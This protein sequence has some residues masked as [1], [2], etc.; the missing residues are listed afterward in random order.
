MKLGKTTGEL[1]NKTSEGQCK[2]G[3]ERWNIEDQT[4]SNDKG[5]YQCQV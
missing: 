2:Q 4:S 5:E 1:K 3:K